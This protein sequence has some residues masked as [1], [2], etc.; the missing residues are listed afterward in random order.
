MKKLKILVI[1]DEPNVCT[2]LTE[3]LE[4]KGYTPQIA[5]SG[6]EALDILTAGNVDLV[7][8][9][10][11]MPEMNGMEVLER[12]KLM[13]PAIPVVIVSGVRD[14][15]MADNIIKMGASDYVPKPI[16]LE[17]LEQSIL[18]SIPRSI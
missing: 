10:I 12:I 5:Y 1:D 11:I 18:L 6:P 17:R 7:L 2:F 15:D 13:N 4:F 3:F 8:L 14:K 16:D 9:D